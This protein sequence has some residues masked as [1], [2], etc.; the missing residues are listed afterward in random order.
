M[1][2]HISGFASNIPLGPMPGL[3]LAFAGLFGLGLGV[4]RVTLSAGQIA[5]AAIR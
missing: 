3:L 1:R 2:T 5:A 4:R